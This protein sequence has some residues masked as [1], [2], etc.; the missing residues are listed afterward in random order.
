MVAWSSL[1][2]VEQFRGLI[3]RRAV[4]RR[5]DHPTVV[6]GSTQGEDMLDPEAVR[7]G[8]AEVVRR[9]G[10]G[11]AVLLRPGDHLWV[12]AWIPRHD[13]LWRVDV[14]EAAHWAGEWWRAA[15]ASA[16][17]GGCT[18]HQGGADPG[19][20]GRAICFSGRGPGEVFHGGAKVMGLSQWRSREG[21]LFHTCAYSRWEAEP[22]VGLL[23]LDEPTRTEWADELALSAVGL[24]D[25]IGPGSGAG[26]DTLPGNA[27]ESAQGTVA[28]ALLSTF[29]H[30]GNAAPHPTS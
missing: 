10:G 4:V 29:P 2:D 22:L 25:L 24:M 1:A 28:Q 3:L 12:D 23:D 6:L 18:V 20:F 9:R 27:A 13:P 14:S 15:L 7:A 17:V 8:G 5:V 26:S 19:P 16:G 21:A 11:G 30:W